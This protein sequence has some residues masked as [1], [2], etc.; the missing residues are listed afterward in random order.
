MTSGK[1]SGLVHELL[2]LCMALFA[3]VVLIVKTIPCYFKTME[4]LLWNIL[5]SHIKK[6]E[7]TLPSL[8]L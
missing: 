1:D 7:E 8:W 6:Y 4:P 2:L 3:V 5:C